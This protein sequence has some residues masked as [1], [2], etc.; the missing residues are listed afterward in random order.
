MAY[1]L[2]LEN[3]VWALGALCNLNRVPFDVKL[4]LQHFP[5]PYD[6]N[7]LQHALQSY[8]FK[9]ELQ[10]ISIQEIHAASFPVVV[11]LKPVA[12]NATGTDDIAVSS[13]QSA[14]SSI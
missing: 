4:L 7:Q 8:G 9:T 2:R 10:D 3:F 5:P 6:V 11:I 13:Q 12:M 1:P 14:V